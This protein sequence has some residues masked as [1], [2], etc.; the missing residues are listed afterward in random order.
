M[1][2]VLSMAMFRSAGCLG[3]W[4]TLVVSM[5]GAAAFAAPAD[6]AEGL[7]K[8]G[9][10]LRKAF[11]D[12]EALEQ[13]QRAYELAPTPRIE[14]QVGAA[15]QALGRW[16]DAETHIAHALRSRTDGWIMKNHGVLEQALMTIRSHLGRLDIL[17]NPVGAEIRVDGRDVGKAPL[18]E[19]V[20]VSIGSV[21]VEIRA[22]G[23]YSATRNVTVAG[24]ELTRESISLTPVSS[25]RPPR[26][27][28][29]GSL[30]PPGS[31]GSD[32]PK[33]MD[34]PRT[35]EADRP[36]RSDRAE[37]RPVDVAP[38]SPGS[39]RRPLAWT[40]AAGAVVFAAGG[41]GGL[42]VRN[43]KAGDYNSLLDRTGCT[44]ANAGPCEALR[45]DGN[46]AQTLAI[47]SFSVAGALAITSTILFATLPS[48]SPRPV[49][50]ALQACT[51]NVSAPR[52]TCALSF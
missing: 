3:F 44:G 12:R 21:V 19:P 14:A 29:E 46:R 30:E 13:F 25:S 31:P 11:K 5:T 22:P 6:E 7:V 40:L 32:S 28:D 26:S 36:P 35:T 24:T 16:V 39:W 4:V 9:I 47:V 52:V 1:G 10:E 42:V 49:A 50:T 43:G 18:P 20:R 38:E 15:E 51:V 17:A 23:Y 8:R 33:P 2:D 41:V 37:S 48:A 34:P 45:A 27:G